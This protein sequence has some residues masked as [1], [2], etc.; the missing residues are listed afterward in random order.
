VYGRVEA[1]I[2]FASQDQSFVPR[3]ASAKSKPAQL[4][5]KSVTE[6]YA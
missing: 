4:S 6:F 2:T 3:E 1:R 5:E